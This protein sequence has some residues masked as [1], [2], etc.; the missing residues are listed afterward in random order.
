LDN[1]TLVKPFP[2][3]VTP[4]PGNWYLVSPTEKRTVKKVKQ[5]REWLLKKISEDDSLVARRLASLVT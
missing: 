2:G 1:G 5:F 4:A 3:L